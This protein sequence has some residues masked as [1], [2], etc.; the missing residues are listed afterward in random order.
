MTQQGGQS[1]SEVR[2]ERDTNTAVHIEHRPDCVSD[3]QAKD[4]YLTFRDTYCSGIVA[5]CGEPQF[6]T[7]ISDKHT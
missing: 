2:G 5:L 3:Y 7:V 6:Q 4:F 1:R